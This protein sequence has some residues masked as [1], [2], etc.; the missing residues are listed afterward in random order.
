MDSQ[1]RSEFGN[2][3]RDGFERPQFIAELMQTMAQNGYRY[4]SMD[5]DVYTFYHP[6]H[7]QTIFYET[8]TVFPYALGQ[9]H[10]E[11]ETL[12]MCG[13]SM[14]DMP[15][16]FLSSFLHIITSSI[17]LL[18]T[19][20]RHLLASKRVSTM[21]IDTAWEYYLISNHVTTEITSHITVVPYLLSKPPSNEE[22]DD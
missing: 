9:R 7:R 4:L 5:S 15:P 17:T 21:V 2:D 19:E 6:I 8:N 10:L 16:D 11:C 14:T 3:C 18:E 13:F 1:P 22:T 20:E 12:V